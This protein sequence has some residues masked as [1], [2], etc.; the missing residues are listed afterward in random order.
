M[1]AGTQKNRRA[2]GCLRDQKAISGRP[3]VLPCIDAIRFALV[4][5]TELQE[6]DG[7]NRTVPLGSSFCKKE[8]PAGPGGLDGSWLPPLLYRYGRRCD[9]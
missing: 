3:P 7:G 9:A 5:A 1:L 2:M 4:A 6:A 8:E